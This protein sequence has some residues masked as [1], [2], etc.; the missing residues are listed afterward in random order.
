MKFLLLDLDGTIFDFN[1][2][3]HDALKTTFSAFGVVPTD[4]LI[5]RYLEINAPLWK[6]LERGEITREALLLKRFQL[7][8]DE[9]GLGLVPKDVQAMYQYELSKRCFFLDGAEE[10]LS[11]LAEEYEIYAVTNG[12]LLV[13]RPR[14]ENAKLDRFFKDYFI[15]EEVGYAKPDKRFFDVVFEKIADFDPEEAIVVGDSLSSDILGAKNAG[16]I[17]I[18]YNPEMHANNTGIIPD[19]EITNLVE[20]KEILS[21]L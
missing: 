11:S 18:Y 5:K 7:L 1:A 21:K 12:N 20:I 13:Q 14:I 15:S 8:S 16:L 3:E 19:Y 17:S 10:L 9:F 2:A 6:C 4:N